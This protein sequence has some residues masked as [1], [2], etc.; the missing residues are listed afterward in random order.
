[1]CMII[2]Y[3]NSI[4]LLKG[5]KEFYFF[6]DIGPLLLKILFLYIFRSSMELRKKE[7]IR[8]NDF[9]DIMLDTLK[10]FQVY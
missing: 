5:A 3:Y 2:V 9:I 10:D 7:N 1:M 4:D 8:K 6:K